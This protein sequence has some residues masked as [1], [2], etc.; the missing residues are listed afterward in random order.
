M[1]EEGAVTQGV[2]K[3]TDGSSEDGEQT[4]CP[5]SSSVSQSFPTVNGVKATVNVH[6]NEAH[7]FI[8]LL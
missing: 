3:K 1:V 5:L 8:I 4:G 6:S 7:P 2:G